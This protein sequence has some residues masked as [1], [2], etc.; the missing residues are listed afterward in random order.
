MNTCHPCDFI[1]L[2]LIHMHSNGAA[3]R[4]KTN[5]DLVEVF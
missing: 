3:E 1:L 4:T 5:I 2:I